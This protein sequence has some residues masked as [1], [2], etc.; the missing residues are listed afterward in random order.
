LSRP[1]T[2][3]LP[4]V[5]RRALI[6]ALAAAAS[7]VAAQPLPG[8]FENWRRLFGGPEAAVDAAERQRLLAEGEAQ[9]AAGDAQAAQDSF[10]R[11]A[12]LMHAPDTECSI[13]RA[14]MQLG[15]YRQAL[16]FCAH[17]AL[18]HRGFAGGVALYAWLLQL[19]GQ[20]AIAQRLLAEAA[21]RQPDDEAVRVARTQLAAPWPLPQ[22]P[23][24]SAPLRAAP[25]GHGV[26]VD[27]ARS[28]IAGTATLLAGGQAALVPLATLQS[29]RELWLRN[30]L[31][32]TV[33]ARVDRADEPTGLAM[34]SLDQALA[35]PA[36]L[37]ISR[38]AP[39][40][41][42]PAAV[43]EF[44]AGG[45]ASAA[46]PWLRLGFFGRVPMS[47][48][49]ALGVAMPAGARGGPVFDRAGLLA[50]LALPGADGAD[51]LLT[52]DQWPLASGLP[53]ADAVPGAA[54]A[55]V[56]S[57]YETAFRLALQV[58]VESAG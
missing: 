40:A 26:Q 53:V 15:Q 12:M 5:G 57:V 43:V 18:A 25:H 2:A 19:G 7:P 10:Q 54:P 28:R 41:G 1:A 23:L 37:A 46:W 11:A 9:L 17:A 48:P 32:E 51:R 33:R 34:L 13:V 3:G 35:M 44:A 22:G 6:V 4:R 45:A 29:A 14:Q 8:S 36:D 39:F 27:A 50:G 21:E 30:G 16:A 58:I 52:V 49:R 55:G 42:S 47:G 56:D 38:R 20:S 24:L 31:G